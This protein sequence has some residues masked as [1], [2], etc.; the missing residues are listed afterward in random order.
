[1]NEIEQCRKDISYESEDLTDV[2]YD[3]LEKGWATWD[4]GTKIGWLY[5]DDFEWYKKEFLDEIKSHGKGFIFND[6][7]E[8]SRFTLWAKK[9]C[10]Y[11]GILFTFPE[12]RFDIYENAIV[13]CYYYPIEK[14]NPT[15]FWIS[16]NRLLL[17][18]DL[19]KIYKL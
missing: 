9:H 19:Y 6:G 10:P 18:E 12:K 15:C 11:S 8:P 17:S 3:K 1:M 7:V 4:I 13:C 2:K 5:K 16:L 14:E